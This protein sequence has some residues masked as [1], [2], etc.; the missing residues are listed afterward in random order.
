MYHATKHF[1]AVHIM[2]DGY[3]AYDTAVEELTPF[4]CVGDIYNQTVYDVPHHEY[5]VST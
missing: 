1:T 2:H 3:D 4:T 5:A